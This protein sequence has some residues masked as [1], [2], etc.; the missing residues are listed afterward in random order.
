M[1]FA[2][3]HDYNESP[4]V[5]LVTAAARQLVAA[6][7]P[8]PTPDDGITR[9]ASMLPTVQA[10]ITTREREA[11]VTT[12]PTRVQAKLNQ[13]FGK[14]NLVQC[15]ASEACFAPCVIAVVQVCLPRA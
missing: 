7:S 8:R 3:N 5:S 2:D 6:P 13:P 14:D 1:D 9:I 11:F 12:L 15:F 10:L 4:C